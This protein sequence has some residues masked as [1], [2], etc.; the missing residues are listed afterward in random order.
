M[1]L[2]SLLKTLV[3]APLLA[4]ALAQ[5][6]SDWPNR[7][8][9]FIAP[10]AT[11]GPS[12]QAARVLA[13][14]LAEALGRPVIVENVAGA[15]STLGLTRVAQAEPDGYTIGLGHVAPLSMAPHMYDKLAYDPAKSFTPITLLSD[16]VNV[17]VVRSDGPYQSVD[18]L[19]RA[20]RDKPGALTYGSAGV[21]SSNHLSGE[22]LAAL[23]G[24]RMTHVPYK[25]SAPSMVDLIGGRLDFMF[26]VLLNSMP[27]IQ[28]GKLRVLGV[29]NLDGIAALPGVPPIARW[30]SGF[31]VLGWVAL[32]GPAGMPAPV[33]A[34]FNAEL[35]RI[36]KLP[37]VIKAFAGIGF[38]ARTSTPAELQSVIEKD[39]KL[40]GPIIRSAGVRAN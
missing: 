26:D 23:T 39:L 2:R 11:G 12:D 37:E 32:V 4:C 22:L 15:G 5:A 27:H 20:A 28:S 9:R 24:L 30:V 16:Y 34:R 40:W 1:I 10:F 3:L 36:M 35:V 6:Q 29:T 21:G 33:V 31:E 19:L 38:D 14:R 8:I 25:G 13:P 17:L 18:D 7:P